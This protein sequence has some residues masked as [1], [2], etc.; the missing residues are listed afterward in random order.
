M[1]GYC[2]LNDALADPNVVE[3]VE[4]NPRLLVRAMAEKV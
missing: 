1:S 3:P 4:W 2:A